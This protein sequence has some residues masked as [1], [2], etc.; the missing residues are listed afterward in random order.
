MTWIIANTG[1]IVVGIILLFVVYLAIRKIVNDKKN[2]TGS[3][4]CGCSGC[5]MS[6]V[7]HSEKKDNK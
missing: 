3:C 7:C 5:A 1:S 2:G 6:N 4:S